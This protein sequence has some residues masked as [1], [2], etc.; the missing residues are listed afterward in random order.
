MYGFYGN[1]DDDDDDDDDTDTINKLLTLFTYRILSSC[2]NS[3]LQKYRQL[4][5]VLDYT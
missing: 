3:R 4:V 5:C 2:R 1:K